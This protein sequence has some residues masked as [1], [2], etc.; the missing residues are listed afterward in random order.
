MLEV[1]GR[2]GVGRSARWTASSF[3]T[4]TPNV[5]YTGDTSIPLPSGYDLVFTNR[6]D[7]H[8]LH[9]VIGPDNGDILVPHGFYPPL[10]QMRGGR[11]DFG[12]IDGTGISVVRGD[13][14]A[15][16]DQVK[17]SDTEI[18]ELENRLRNDLRRI[19]MELNQKEP[20]KPAFDE[21]TASSPSPKKEPEEELKALVIA[22]SI[23]S[24]F[25]GAYVNVLSLNRALDEKIRNLRGNH[26]T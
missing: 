17:S 1:L 22:E 13:P 5:I 10:S 9:A 8:S 24:P 18:V 23:G 20:A 6:G 25:T 16:A 3:K 11:T 7:S 4:L 19:E 2:S 15:I 21:K 26:G 14:G 12:I